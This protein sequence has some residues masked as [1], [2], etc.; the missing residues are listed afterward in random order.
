MTASDP[1]PTPT[2]RRTRGKR[3]PGAA[4][5]VAV[6]PDTADRIDKLV[7]HFS[8]DFTVTRQQVVELAVKTLERS[9]LDGAEAALRRAGKP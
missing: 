1:V 3:R 4:S 6:T 7:E 9:A 8:R 5:S 2:P